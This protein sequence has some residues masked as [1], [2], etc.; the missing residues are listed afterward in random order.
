MAKN[1]HQASAR[2]I[3]SRAQKQVSAKQG[4]TREIEVKVIGIPL[5][6][7]LLT[8]K[9]HRAVPLFFGTIHDI[10][11]TSP[12][13]SSSDVL[14]LRKSVSYLP[15]PMSVFVADYTVATHC[16][17]YACSFQ[18]SASQIISQHPLPAKKLSVHQPSLRSSKVASSLVKR[19]LPSSGCCIPSL[20]LCYKQ[21]LAKKKAKQMIEHTLALTPLTPLEHVHMF[22][23]SLQFFKAKERKKE[24]KSFSYLH[25]R[26]D[27]DHYVFLSETNVS[28]PPFLEI[29][30]P[31]YTAIKRCAAS[32]GI[33][34]SLL[35][36][37][38]TSELIAYYTR[39]SASSESSALLSK[40][41][42]RKTA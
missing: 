13:L 14:R 27:L 37:W 35:Y 6:E 7:I 9:K 38:G 25:C 39:G 28:I 15:L 30:G 19:S 41:I 17:R 40:K 3:A 11:Y 36:A 10:F 29:E 42:S 4:A 8:L 20:D 23:G 5:K 32:L 33:S 31:S 16:K 1:I 12:T 2:L 34:S 21:F 18:P 26:I 24:R 22:L